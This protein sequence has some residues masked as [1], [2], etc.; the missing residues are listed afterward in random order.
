MYELPKFRDHPR[1]NSAINKSYIICVVVCNLT[2][3]Y[4]NPIV[5]K[6]N[7]TVRTVLICWKGVSLKHF[8]HRLKQ[9]KSFKGN[10]ISG[11]YRHQFM[12]CL[13]NFFSN[14]QFEFYFKRNLSG[15]KWEC[16]NMHP[17]LSSYLRPWLVGQ[18]I[19]PATQ[20]RWFDSYWRTKWLRHFFLQRTGWALQ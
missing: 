20:K 7:L 6:I 13:T 2:L 9:F 15:I 10:L 1:L 5:F 8:R 3:G 18:S 14:L 12:I 4:L 16:M 11:A 19:S 17:Q